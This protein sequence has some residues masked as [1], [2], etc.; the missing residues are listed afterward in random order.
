MYDRYIIM[1]IAPF[2]SLV[3][4]SLRLAPII[5]AARFCVIG[6]AKIPRNEFL[7]LDWIY[8]CIRLKRWTI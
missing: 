3:W 5:S 7:Q 6:L 1:I 4:G 8:S 2:D